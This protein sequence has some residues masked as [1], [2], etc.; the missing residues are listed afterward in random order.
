MREVREELE[1]TRSDFATKLGI[2]ANYLYEIETG[3]KN[4]SETLLLLIESRYAINSTWL[5]AG[6]G[7]KSSP[8]SFQTTTAAEIPPIYRDH[9]SKLLAILQGP[10]QKLAGKIEA[11]IEMFY[12]E[13][14][15]EKE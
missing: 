12:E 7:K 5:K 1:L 13:V 8:P 14:K 4:A 2:S 3:R 11:Y 10:N 9:I 6:T 15:K